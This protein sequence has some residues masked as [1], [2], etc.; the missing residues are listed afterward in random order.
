MI[1]WILKEIQ[2]RFEKVFERR[3]R[4]KFGKGIFK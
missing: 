3:I 4:E 1:L 2:K